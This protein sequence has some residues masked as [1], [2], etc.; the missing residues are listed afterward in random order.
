MTCFFE[1]HGIQLAE[2]TGSLR[3]SKVLF[4]LL[5]LCRIRAEGMLD[6]SMAW[7]RLLCAH[8][9]VLFLAPQGRSRGNQETRTLDQFEILSTRPSSHQQDRIRV[10]FSSLSRNP[11]LVLPFCRCVTILLPSLWSRSRPG[12]AASSSS[13]YVVSSDITS[14]VNC[15]GLSPSERR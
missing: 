7:F 15:N 2:P 9:F 1:I 6:R 5:G 10:Y 12:F 14:L 11:W 8:H 13:E 3:T 4:L